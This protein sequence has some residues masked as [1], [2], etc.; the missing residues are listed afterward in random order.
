MCYINILSFISLVDNL[1]EQGPRPQRQGGWLRVCSFLWHVSYTGVKNL[2]WTSPEGR[3]VHWRQ[4]A[5]AP[6]HFQTLPALGTKYR[7]RRWPILTRCLS[8]RCR[9]AGLCGRLPT[10]T[11]SRVPWFPHPPPGWSG[12]E[13]SKLELLTGA[14]QQQNVG[15]QHCSVLLSRSPPRHVRRVLWTGPTGQA[16]HQLKSPG[17]SGEPCVSPEASLCQL[18][19][20]APGPAALEDQNSSVAEGACFNSWFGGE[21]R[22]RRLIAIFFVDKQ[23]TSISRLYKPS[24]CHQYGANY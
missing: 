3:Y 6:L 23:E 11:G 12:S 13:A 20:L 22:C 15:W 19:S 14:G 1:P 21:R 16:G 5:A 24:C 4:L 9:P 17:S 18:F 10:Q 2:W 7:L 8:T